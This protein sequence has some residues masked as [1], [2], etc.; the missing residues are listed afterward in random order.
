MQRTIGSQS[1]VPGIATRMDS[2]H[3]SP[4]FELDALVIGAGFAGCYLLHILRSAGFNVKVVE[5]GSDLG[6]V[7]YWNRYPGARVDSQWP[8]YALSIPEVYDGWTWSEHY[9]GH[10]E[11]RKYFAHV[12]E[13]LDLKKDIEFNKKVTGADWQEETK[14]WKVICD[15]GTWIETKFLI[16]GVGFAAKRYFPPWQG[17][18]KF[19]GTMYHSSFWP[20]DGLDVRGKRMAVIG[21][22][23][24]GVQIIQECAKEIGEDGCLTVFQ[25]TPNLCCPMNQKKISP[26]E[27]EDMKKILGEVFQERLTHDAGFMYSAR[28]NMRAFD[29]SPEE[30][31]AFLEELW[32]LVSSSEACR[33]DLTR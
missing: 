12:N 25:R 14:T 20:K 26:E 1:T 10:E 32:N 6:G 29:H 18:E 15:D 2:P 22:G 27:D 19:K 5:A 24:T 13:K 11:L 33:L 4:E 16:A 21:T 31:E 17:L 23:A 9:P 8:I 28:K 7:W 3:S 30:R